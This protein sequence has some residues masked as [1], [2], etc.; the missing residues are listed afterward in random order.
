MTTLADE[1]AQLLTT[2][3]GVRFFIVGEKPRQ[4][5]PTLF[6]LAVSGRGSLQ[7]D[8]YVKSGRL[9]R[10]QGWLCASV[11]VPCHDEDSR[12]GEP[13]ALKGWRFRLDQGENFIAPFVEKCRAALD[14]LIKEGYTDPQRVAVA[15]TSRG[16]FCAFHFAA[17][18]PRVKWVVAF[19]P[20][21]D[22]PVLEEFRGLENHALTKSLGVA[23][24][25]D[26]LVGKHIWICIGNND[27]R[28]GTDQCFAFTR[29]VAQTDLAADKP[30]TIELHVMPSVGHAIHATAHDEA[31]AWLAATSK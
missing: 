2:A 10:Q 16:G 6:V 15:G 26:N 3:D 22:L 24:L 5:A 13:S 9:L 18:E 20:V 8:D 30:A 28:V 19:A 12:P 27:A 17:N 23:N 25:A 29:K 7:S 14:H 4:P 31:A 21:T 1:P 11:D